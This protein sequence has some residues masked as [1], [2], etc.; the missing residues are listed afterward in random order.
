MNS[1]LEAIMA[2]IADR[3]TNSALEIPI[4]CEVHRQ[5]AQK[6]GRVE[7]ASNDVSAYAIDSHWT[8]PT[9]SKFE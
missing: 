9:C 4:S 1:S 2:G 3:R 7:G 8:S 5:F 6:T